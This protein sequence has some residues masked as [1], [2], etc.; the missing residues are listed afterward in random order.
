[1]STTP[2]HI[3]VLGAC[4]SGDAFRPP[5]D[6]RLLSRSE[7]RLI[8]YQGRTAFNTLASAPLLAR[9]Y[10]LKGVDPQVSASWGYRM[11][12]DELNKRHGDKLLSV[13]SLVDVLV[14]DMVSTFTFAHLVTE[15]GRGFLRSWE[16]ERHVESL[17]AMRVVRLWD[18]PL[19]STV[20]ESFALLDAMTLER[21]DLMLVVHVPDPSFEHGARFGDEETSQRIDFYYRYCD[22]VLTR[23]G[24]R[25]RYVH[26]IR[27]G[28]GRA[29]PDHPNGSHPFNFDAAYLAWVRDQISGLVALHGS[30][31]VDRDRAAQAAASTGHPGGP[32]I[33]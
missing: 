13:A 10:R 30:L 9:E 23:L 8:A 1:M 27:G 31:N 20:L 24:Q 11:V 4:C 16:W 33:T 29:D 2:K 19:E 28:A 22:L 6:F 17:P 26:G 5:T 18:L 25:Y 14:M 15:D 3:A 32:S 21:P 12:L 7:Y